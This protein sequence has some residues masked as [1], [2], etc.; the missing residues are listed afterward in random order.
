MFKKYYRYLTD[1]NL[2]L[3]EALNLAVDV[4]SNCLNNGLYDRILIN[5]DFKCTA[6]HVIIGNNYFENSECDNAFLHY[7]MAHSS[8]VRA[9]NLTR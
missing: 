3:I 5:D 2:P 8:R 7:A 9:E 4:L 6:L 1:K